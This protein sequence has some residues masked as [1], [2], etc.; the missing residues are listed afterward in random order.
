MARK[1]DAGA[2]MKRSDFYFIDP[3]ALIVQEEVR[4]RHKKPNDEDVINMAVSLATH[5]QRQPV[6]CRKV[7]GDKLEL[8]L[9]FTRT[10]GARLLRKGFKDLEGNDYHDP[11]FKVKVTL[12]DCND[13][14]AFIHNIVENAHRKQTSPIDDAHNQRKLR[15]QHGM[16]DTEIKVLYRYTDP[17]KVGRLRRLLALPDNIQDLVHEDRLPVAGALDLLDIADDAKRQEAY[18]LV[19]SKANGVENGNVTAAEIRPFIREAILN[20]DSLPPEEKGGGKKEPTP[21]PKYMPRSMR[22]LRQY[23]QQKKETHGQDEVKKFCDVL[24]LWLAGKRANKSLD[25][26]FEDLVDCERA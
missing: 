21:P 2:D 19:L 20:D 16:N 17:A 1:L 11:D 12:S 13:K 15:D 10:A 24:D 25:K 8:K 9:G 14:E 7:A 23:L 6:E 22:E 4:G 5:G 3:F 18:D 26:C